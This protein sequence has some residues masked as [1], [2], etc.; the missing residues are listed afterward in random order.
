MNRVFKKDAK[1]F[2]ESVKSLREL[3]TPESENHMYDE[4]MQ[5]GFIMPVLI[6]GEVHEDKDGKQTISE[7]ATFSFPTIASPE[8]QQYFMA[9]TD[10]TELQKYQSKQ[11][12]HAL[13]FGFDDYAA[14]IMQ[15]KEIAGFVVDP[16]GTNV[17]YPRDLV[18]SLKEQ[19]EIMEK[20]HTERIFQANEKVMIG[21]P[22][23]EPKALKDALSAFAKKDKRI[24]ALYLQ[25]M[26]QKD[27]QSYIIAVDADM[28]DPR[29]IFS[30]LAD[31]CRMHLDGMYLDIVDVR[32]ELGMHILEK[33]EPFYKKMFYKKPWIPFLA[34][35]ED[36]F[37]LKDGRCVVGVEV[38]HGKLS[39]NGEIV[40]L[41]EQQEPL[42]ISAALGIEYGKER[43]KVAR[44][45]ENGKYGS[46]FGILMKDHDKEY[47]KGYYLKGK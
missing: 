17:V 36:C 44:L 20:G 23:K 24:Q 13:T 38:L 47:K 26:M 37:Y 41:N 16:Y 8:G 45:Q 31:S 5:V 39:D 21:E 4:L 33:A 22:A 34:K 40:C 30:Q 27:Q 29:S 6:N 43:V 18:Q 12:L 15:N 28:K 3:Q 32:S 1:D 9:F 14:V 10:G 2:I 42:F 25:L 19:K 7:G 46:H 11:P 35:I